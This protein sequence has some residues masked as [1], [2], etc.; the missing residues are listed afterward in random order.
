M[1]APPCSCRTG[2]KS[3]EESARDSLRSSVSSPGIPNTYLTPS[4]SRHSTKT[5]DA[6]RSLISPPYLTAVARPLTAIHRADLSRRGV[7]ALLTAAV[8]LAA[9]TAAARADGTFYIRGGGDGHGIGM[10]QYGAYGYALHGAGYKTILAHYY[11][12]TALSTTDARHTVRVLLATSR[13]SFSGAA[14]V[15]G[16]STR[17]APSTTYTVKAAG[18]RLTITNPA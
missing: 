16:A 3:I 13:A 8:L 6:L 2:T 11:Q 12:G 4:D 10:S 5:S 1:Y 15:S 9:F 18:S 7:R 17:L 14:S